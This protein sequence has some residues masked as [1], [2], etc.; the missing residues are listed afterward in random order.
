M[1]DV[2]ELNQTG[3]RLTGACSGVYFLFQDDELVYIGQG[4]N[5]LL[6]VAEHTR[7]DSVKQFNHWNF[8]PI[9]D[10]R[11]RKACEAELRAKY[12]PKFNLI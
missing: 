11:E 7:K 9:D 6:R 12:K 1:I 10:E 4:W 8:I 5:C 3:N 2:D